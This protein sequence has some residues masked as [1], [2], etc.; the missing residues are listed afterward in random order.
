[1][2]DMTL[3]NVDL[4]SWLERCVGE[5][6]WGRFQENS[7]ADLITATTCY[8]SFEGLE[9]TI[10]FSSSIIPIMKA[11][12]HELRLQFYDAYV[13][14]LVSKYSANEYAQAVL[15]QKDKEDFEKAAVLKNTVLK[16]NGGL[17][18]IETKTVD[19]F[20][21]GDFIF[22]VSDGNRQS[23]TIDG[24]VVAYCREV[25]FP[26]DEMS[27]NAIRKWVCQIIKGVRQQQKARNDSAHGRIIQNKKDAEKAI[28]DIVSVEKLL[29]II[30]C[31]PFLK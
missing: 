29:A 2:T 9:T 28:R 18:Y 16:Y 22:T 24:P 4:E 25:L 23:P 12:E 6:A 3:A 31:P 17:A 5:A 7:K 11:L 8:K 14:Y 21:L 1:M 30:V 27:N 20:T 13:A 10:D 15:P 19:Y 26:D